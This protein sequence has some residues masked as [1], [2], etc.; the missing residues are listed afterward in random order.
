[1]SVCH[2]VCAG[3]CAGMCVSLCVCH[4]VCAGVCVGVFECFH[5]CV[6]WCVLVFISLIQAYS[7]PSFSIPDLR[8]SPESSLPEVHSAGMPATGRLRM[9]DEHDS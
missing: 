1:M 9:G 4:F 8:Q 3:V 6:C 7:F 5:R 2:F